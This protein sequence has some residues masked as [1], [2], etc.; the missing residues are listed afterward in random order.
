[1]SGEQFRKWRR[2]HDLTL[3]QVSDIVG[4]STCTLSKW[5]HNKREINDSTENRLYKL[6]Q[7]MK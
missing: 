5:E 1:M 2:E 3:Q 6:T 7:I 4:V